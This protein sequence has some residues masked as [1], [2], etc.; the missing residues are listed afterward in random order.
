[1][2]VGQLA[3]LELDRLG[4][5]VDDERDFRHDQALSYQ[6]SAPS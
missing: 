1:M 5:A 3:G 2:R 4:F 6:L